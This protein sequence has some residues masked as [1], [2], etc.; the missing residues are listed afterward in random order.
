MLVSG[1]RKRERERTLFKELLGPVSQNILIHANT[2]IP[3]DTVTMYVI[4]WKRKQ[5]LASWEREGKA[6]TH[7]NRH[8]HI[9]FR[10][11]CLKIRNSNVS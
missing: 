7:T 8:T 6:G 2:V 5:L 1:S 11:Q 10:Q 4:I 3:A 9:L